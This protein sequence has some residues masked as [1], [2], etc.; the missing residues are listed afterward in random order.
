MQG[1]TRRE[2]TCPE[3]LWLQVAVWA[4]ET[5]FTLHAQ[6]DSRRVYRKGHWLLMPTAWVEIHQQGRQVS[7]AAWIKADLYL[8]LNLMTG[9]KAE[10]GIES[11]GLTAALPRRRAR[12]AVN[13]LLAR[14]G[15]QPLA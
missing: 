9:R 6:E 1:R 3:D 15:Q 8:V 4:A 2:F 12:A 11:G 10:A 14:L 5:G 13:R 7:L